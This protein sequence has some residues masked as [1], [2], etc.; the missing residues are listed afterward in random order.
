MGDLENTRVYEIHHEIYETWEV[1]FSNGIACAA[2]QVYY[3]KRNYQP[4]E[5]DN[6]TPRK[7]NWLEG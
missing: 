4:L 3:I 2:R 7:R 5:Q 6:T 1:M